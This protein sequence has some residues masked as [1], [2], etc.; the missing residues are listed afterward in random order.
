[1]VWFMEQR[2]HR[3][4]GPPGVS[5]SRR[6]HSS[7]EPHLV[8][9]V[10]LVPGTLGAKK[11]VAAGPYGSRFPEG[12]FEVI[13][14]LHPTDGRRSA[15]SLSS[16]VANMRAEG[17]AI[18]VFE[19]AFASSRRMS[20]SMSSM[21]APLDSWPQ[22]LAVGAAD[23]VAA[24]DLLG[25][26]KRDRS[27]QHC[28]V[29]PP[30]SVLSR[31][32]GATARRASSV[33][34]ITHWGMD[35]VNAH[36]QDAKGV[37]VGVVDSGVDRSHP[38]L[39][40]AVFSYQNFTAESDKDNDGHGTHV[41]GI[42]AG[43]GVWPGGMKGVS[44]ARL[45]VCK[46]LGERYSATAYYRAL[47]AAAEGAKIV[48]LSLGGTVFDQAEHDIIVNAQGRG[49]LFIAAMGNDYDGGNE[50]NY[51]AALRGVVAVGAIGEDLTHA[52]F[53]N[54]GDH[55]AV[56]APGV[57]IWSTIPTHKSN[58]FP[59]QKNYAACKGTSMAT[60]FVSGVTAVL[61][62]KDQPADAS[63]VVEQIPVQFCPGQTGWTDALGRGFVS[64]PAQEG[65]KR[66]PRR[67]AKKAELDL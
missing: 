12:A 59:K 9:C 20:G 52:E 23:W 43:R 16:L 15:S 65:A 40:E 22:I 61:Y 45:V 46:G 36:G 28:Y 3:Y 6:A 8:P 21:G 5:S 19:D 57:E 66:Q 37:L 39:K 29:A 24:G 60:P 55:I 26:M 58:I 1:M 11:M 17:R 50:T 38:D 25:E 47:R 2:K 48:N 7:R 42:I 30:R 18:E 31:T 32:S 10:S 63:T 35:C 13:A 51:P 44:N 67:K 64:F 41:C 53:S 56:V 49:V 33:K 62:A 27:V 54:S 34:P 14:I 4:V